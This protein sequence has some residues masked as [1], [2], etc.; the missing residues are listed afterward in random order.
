MVSRFYLAFVATLTTGARGLVSRSSIVSTTTC[1]S[2]A[3]WS[4]ADLLRE[5]AQMSVDLD[6][7]P[8]MP[9]TIRVEAELLDPIS[10]DFENFATLLENKNSNADGNVIATKIVHFQR[11]GQGYHNL[12]GDVLRDAG[13]KPDIFS[14]DPSINPWVRPEI[15]DS[16][17]TELG[18]RQCI[19]QQKIARLL[20]PQVMIVSP[21]LRAIQT[22]KLSFKET[23]LL[24]WPL[25]R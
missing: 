2:A 15:V 11:H 21:L 18:K 17:L 4:E 6:E 1:L 3:A 8:P 23:G 13:I 25:L 9:R 20:K 7:T 24:S 14:S 10:T 19:G 5:K 12:L 16:P 22:S